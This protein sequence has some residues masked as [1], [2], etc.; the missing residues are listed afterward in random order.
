MENWQRNRPRTGLTATIDVPLLCT[1]IENYGD[2]Q[3]DDMLMPVG[4]PL[5]L[6]GVVRQWRL[7]RGTK[8]S[9]LTKL[10]ADY[11]LERHLI[12]VNE[13]APQWTEGAI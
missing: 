2:G 1:M 8:F 4:W 11:D 13:E 7:H 9:D 10:L 6:E 12:E 5:H 3:L